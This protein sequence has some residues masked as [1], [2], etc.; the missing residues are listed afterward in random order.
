MILLRGNHIYVKV[1]GPLRMNSNDF[2]K[3][4]TVRTHLLG[5]AWLI[6]SWE[7]PS[8]THSPH[9]YN[10]TQ[11]RFQHRFQQYHSHQTQE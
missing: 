4:F 10:T 7:E 2:L 1:F 11:D 6:P 9:I 8:N 3:S 5:Q